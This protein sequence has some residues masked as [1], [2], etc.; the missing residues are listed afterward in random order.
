MYCEFIRLIGNNF[1]LSVKKGKSVIICIYTVLIF[2]ASF[3][4]WTLSYTIICYWNR[5]IFHVTAND[6]VCMLFAPDKYTFS[7]EYVDIQTLK[8][9]PHETSYNQLYLHTSG[10]QYYSWLKEKNILWSMFTQSRVTLDW[11]K[12]HFN[13]WYYLLLLFYVC[14][15]QGYSWLKEKNTNGEDGGQR[16]RELGALAGRLGKKKHVMRYKFYMQHRVY[17]WSLCEI[18]AQISLP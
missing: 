5:L 17:I 9:R 2:L 18:I 6:A 16:L 7:D 4:T 11:K 13:L 12:K 3:F 8:A 10:L 1:F 14:T 15:Q